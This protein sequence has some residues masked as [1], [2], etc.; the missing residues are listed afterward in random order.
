MEILPACTTAV[1]SSSPFR[2]GEQIALTMLE[3]R[4]LTY[5][6]NFSLII[7]LSNGTTGRI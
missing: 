2:L 3:E 4:K 1:V 6:E 7:P 5:R